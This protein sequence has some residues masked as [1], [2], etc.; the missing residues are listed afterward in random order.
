[1]ES[2]LAFSFSD[3]E[4]TDFLP[5]D[6]E[7]QFFTRWADFN[8]HDPGVTS[9][10]AL[11]F[12]YE[13]FT[14]RLNLPISVLLQGK[15]ENAFSSWSVHDLR[16]FYAVTVDDYRRVL[17]RLKDVANAVVFPCVE[18]NVAQGTLVPK[19]LLTIEAAAFSSYLMPF[20]DRL[21]V[22]YRALG[23]YFNRMAK[24]RHFVNSNLKP[25]DVKVDVTFRYRE[26]S[27]L[28]K[29]KLIC[30]VRE[31]LLPRLKPMNF[32]YLKNAQELI[33]SEHFGPV[34]VLNSNQVIST[35]AIHKE[36]YRESIAVSEIYDVLE[37]LNFLKSVNSVQIALSTRGNYTGTVLQ[38][39]RYCFTPLNSIVINKD[40]YTQLLPSLPC[41]G[42]ESIIDNLEAESAEVR[43][44]QLGK[45]YSIQESFPSNYGIGSNLSDKTSTELARSANF[46]AY[47]Y[48]LDQV[49]A[50]YL[51]QLGN[52]PRI[53]TVNDEVCGIKQNNLEDYPYYEDLDI[54]R[55]DCTQGAPKDQ[56]NCNDMLIEPIFRERRLNY[57]LA[58]NGWTTG[59]EIPTQTNN[60]TL[61]LIK[62]S[63]LDLVHNPGKCTTHVNTGLNFIFRSKSLVMLQEMVRV[64]LQTE[65]TDVRVLEHVFLQ[66]VWNQER[67]MDFDITIFLFSDKR[68]LNKNVE[69]IWYLKRLVREIVPVH[70][71]FN[72]VWCDQG[73]RTFDAMLN[74][75][76]PPNDIFYFDNE[77]TRHQHQAM[78]WLLS[79][80]GSNPI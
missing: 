17:S 4:F 6:P 58:Q 49:R 5:E 71:L 68:D 74:A 42:R 79:E 3:T 72:L 76:F 57:L 47:L 51:A 55:K 24:D 60:E 75:A 46:R 67:T 8:I 61:L 70:I 65:I 38:L 56:V 39:G 15:K 13:D 25:V 1:M 59:R 43:D 19:S 9:Y 34:G 27:E 29:A 40:S 66:P 33:E 2:S 16:P 7:D 48:F 26:D 22:Q 45:F 62:R 11:Q 77:I 50:D 21:V 78:I 69:L 18:P 28:N 20:S 41:E 63:F 14:Y 53:F 80:L 73:I 23:E 36:C 12:S 64:L 31:F 44:H 35:E 32:R 30:A 52:F 37:S 10:E 54:S